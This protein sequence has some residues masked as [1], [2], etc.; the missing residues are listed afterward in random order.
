MKNVFTIIGST[1]IVAL[2]ITIAMLITQEITVKYTYKSEVVSYDMI[3]TNGWSGW[4]NVMV[5]HNEFYVKAYALT[6]DLR[7]KDLIRITRHGEGAIYNVNEE[8]Y[9][10]GD[11]KTFTAPIAKYMYGNNDATWKLY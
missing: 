6:S 2:M 3:L 5:Y 11:S 4:S 1:I 10:L 8:R 7:G 9:F